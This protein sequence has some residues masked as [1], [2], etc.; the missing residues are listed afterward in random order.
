MSHDLTEHCTQRIAERTAYS[1]RELQALWD[2]A[3]TA[4]IFDFV[5]FG[6]RKHRGAIYRVAKFY[7][8]ETL[9]VK[10]LTTGRF[11]TVIKAK[12]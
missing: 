9:I 8:E 10:S 2:R 11:I 3:R 7:G 1:A 12:G 4:T 5:W 6:A